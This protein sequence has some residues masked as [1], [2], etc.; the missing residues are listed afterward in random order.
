VGWAVTYFVKLGRPLEATETDALAAWEKEHF[1]LDP[2]NPKWVEK[3][4]GLLPD[5]EVARLARDHSRQMAGLMTLRYAIKDAD[6]AGFM[7]TRS[8]ASYRRTVISF[9]SLESLFPFATIRISD[10]HYATNARPGEIDLKELHAGARYGSEPAPEPAEPAPDED[11]DR[12]QEEIAA[13]LA[14]AREDFERWRRSRGG[15]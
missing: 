1:T 12:E 5:E 14:R 7:Q 6:F 4:R 13:M 3:W 9:Q 8:M 11:E 2:V 15:Q 10:D